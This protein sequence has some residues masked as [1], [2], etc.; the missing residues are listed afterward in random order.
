[1]KKTYTLALA[2][3]GLLTLAM[4]G[5]ALAFNGG[6]VTHCDGCHPMHNSADNPRAGSAMSNDLMKGSDASSTCL[7]CHND[8][9]G[10]HVASANGANVNQV[11][12]FFWVGMD[13][14]YRYYS[15]GEKTGD[16][17]N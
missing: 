7:N 10:Y 5:N 1:M 15:R 4:G 11:G 2:G 9:G 14:T 12:D 3:A 6:G 17:P 16:V 8:A 13:G